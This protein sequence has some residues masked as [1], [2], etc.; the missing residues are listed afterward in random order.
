MSRSGFSVILQAVGY[1]QFGTQITLQMKH[2]VA[3]LEEHD[4]VEAGERM[5][6]LL[7]Q[8]EITLP[9]PAFERKLVGLRTR[10]R[11]GLNHI[12][13]RAPFTAAIAFRRA[14][15]V[16]LSDYPGEKIGNPR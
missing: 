9:E 5:R 16:W 11:R 12:D 6:S 13:R 1:E 2:I 4:L 3:L 15:V 10:L 8:V 7:E 14:L